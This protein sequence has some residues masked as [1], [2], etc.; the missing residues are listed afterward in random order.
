MTLYTFVIKE[1]HPNSP[2]Y[3]NF[4]NTSYHGASQIRSPFLTRVACFIVN[5]KRMHVFS[6]P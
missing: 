5:F 2:S 3:V 4:I 1:D 6:L